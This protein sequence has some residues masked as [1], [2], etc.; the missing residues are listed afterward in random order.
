MTSLQLRALSFEELQHA[1]LQKSK[2]L[3]KIRMQCF[4]GVEQKTH[5]LKVIRRTIARMRT[6]LNQKLQHDTK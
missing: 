5:Q 6:I 2:E 3:F 4:A 1:I